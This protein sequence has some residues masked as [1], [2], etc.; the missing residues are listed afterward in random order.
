MWVC[1]LHVKKQFQRE[2]AREGAGVCARKCV[3]AGVGEGSGG[4]AGRCNYRSQFRVMVPL[5]MSAVD[6]P[7]SSFHLV[8]TQ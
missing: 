7:Q 5:M 8:F 2:R 6:Q 3:R 4:E 1:G